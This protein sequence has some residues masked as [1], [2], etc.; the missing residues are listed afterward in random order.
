MTS[1]AVMIRGA[2]LAPGKGEL[3]DKVQFRLRSVLGAR[4]FRYILLNCPNEQ[5]A[6]I[7]EILPGIKSPTVMPLAT[8]GWSS[9]HTVVRENE[10]WEIIETLKDAG[11]EG[12]LVLPI[13][14][15]VL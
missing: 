4:D 15:L 11:A 14:K 9:V 12:V 6:R 8:G 13:Q 7:T 3:L 10:F 1:E 2:S 5:I